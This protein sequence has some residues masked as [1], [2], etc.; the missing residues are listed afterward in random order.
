MAHTAR[1]AAKGPQGGC[2]HRECPVAN[3]WVNRLIG[4]SRGGP[5]DVYRPDAP[6]RPSG[7]IGPVRL[8]VAR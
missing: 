2:R 7:L 5:Q 1:K 8:L 6:L 3:L 4:T